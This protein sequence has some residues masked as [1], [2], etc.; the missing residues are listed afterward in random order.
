VILIPEISYDFKVIAEAVLQRNRSG[1]RFSLVAVSEGAMSLDSVRFF[2]KAR[3]NSERLHSGPNEEEIAQKLELIEKKAAG[4]TLHLAHQLEKMTSL[5]TRVTILGYVQR[6]GAPS[7]QD[8]LLATQLGTETV[9]FCVQG[10]FG[11]MAAV[12]KGE[13]VPVPISAVAQK[14]KSVPLDHAWLYTARQVGTCL[15]D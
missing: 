4:D 15:G 12:Q 10:C 3:K 1:K 7:A 13:I 9:K 6:G 11:I 2:E 5:V 14:V 8:R